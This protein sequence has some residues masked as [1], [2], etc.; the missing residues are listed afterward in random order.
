MK[1][2]RLATVASLLCLLSFATLAPS[3]TVR[4]PAD[5]IQ[6][7][8]VKLTDVYVSRERMPGTY[9]LSGR[10]RNRSTHAVQHIEIEVSVFDRNEKLGSAR[11]VLDAL[12]FSGQSWTEVPSGESRDF[13]RQLYFGAGTRVP[14]QSLRV[15]CRVTSVLASPSPS[16]CINMDETVST[17][18]ISVEGETG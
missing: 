13:E 2:F 18:V 17:Q 3:E 8:N 1:R 9:G 4:L 10:V 15:V 7:V 14:A 11:L 6:L 5:E 12:T 16:L